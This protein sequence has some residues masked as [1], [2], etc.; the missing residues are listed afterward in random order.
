MAPEAPI[1]ERPRSLLDLHESAGDLWQEYLRV[2]LVEN[3]FLGFPQDA[4]TG[5][6]DHYVAAP[7]ILQKDRVICSF[8]DGT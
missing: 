3:L 7:Y 6:V 1:R 5:G 8:D 2:Y 4:C